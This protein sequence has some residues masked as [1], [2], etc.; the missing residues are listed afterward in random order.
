MVL[1]PFSLTTMRASGRPRHSATPETRASPPPTGN[2]VNFN[3]DEPE[4][5]TRTR[6][7]GKDMIVNP[8]GTD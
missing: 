5:T 4:F 2:S 7:D 6:R 1:A 8:Q 3:D